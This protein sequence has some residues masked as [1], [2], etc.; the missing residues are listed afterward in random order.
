MSIAP[1]T[2]PAS[3]SISV[4]NSYIQLDVFG[5]LR[6]E[7]LR[8][9]L[10]RQY[11][12][13]E[14]NKQYTG[15]MEDT[16]DAYYFQLA[17]AKLRALVE[18]KTSALAIPAMLLENTLNETIDKTELGPAMNNALM[19]AL[20]GPMG[21]IKTGL[22]G[23]RDEVTV[24][25]KTYNPGEFYAKVIDFDDFVMDQSARSEGELQYEGHRYRIPRQLALESGLFDPQIIEGAPR[26]QLSNQFRGEAEKLKGEQ[27]DPFYLVDTIEL[28]DLCLYG[29]PEVMICTLAGTFGQS[30]QFAREP[31]PYWGPGR[32]PYRK[33]SF[34]SVPNSPIPRAFGARMIDLHDGVRRTAEK[35]FEQMDQLKR[36]NI[37]EPGEEQL[38]ET[39]RQAPDGAWIKG[40]PSAFATVETGGMTQEL[41]PGVDFF[42][43]I[44]N[45]R[46][47]AAQMLGGQGDVSKTATGATII[48]SQAQVRV[49]TMRN[50]R[51]RFMDEIIQDAAWFAQNDPAVGGVSIARIPG[52]EGVEFQNTPELKQGEFGDFAYSTCAYGMDNTDPYT[53]A[54]RLQ[55]AVAMLPTLAQLGPEN[56]SKLVRVFAR[57][58][59]EPILDE[60]SLDPTAM[61]AQMQ[62][63]GQATPPGKQNPPAGSDP[64]QT[65]QNYQ[66]TVNAG[67]AQVRRDASI[68]APANMR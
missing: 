2:D 67:S 5:K 38:A 62:Q 55:S 36:V 47:G 14:Q 66:E 35:I 44:A 54:Q 65:P 18:P 19:H 17:V 49:Q 25:D 12:Q 37:H 57:R 9:M 27:F 33:L 43:N 3:L 23:G 56:F 11:P 48:A 26:L 1:T 28:W 34:F 61:M 46:S 24:L 21:I 31:F 10:G 64:R 22:R 6:L 63:V 4:Y 16:I 68:N 13:G 58:L 40:N 29:G 51:D 60:L 41:M 20:T 59:N 32:G 53:S 45:T 8:R 39:V 50:A 7:V 15:L 42:Q 52:T 30:M